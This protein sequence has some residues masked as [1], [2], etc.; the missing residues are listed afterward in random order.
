MKKFGFDFLATLLMVMAVCVGFASCS[1]DDD[2]VNV[3]KSSLVGTWTSVW[4]KG[5]SIDRDGEK[6]SWDE[7]STGWTIV[8]NADG[9]GY[10][11]EEDGYSDDFTWTLSGNKISVTD[12]DGDTDVWTVVSL[13]GSSLTVSSYEQD[14]YSTDYTEMTFKKTK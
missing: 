4:E 9:T 5:Y 12:E 10:E 7:P 6:E 8:F 3:N 14:K 2:D 13:K 11:Y 1:D